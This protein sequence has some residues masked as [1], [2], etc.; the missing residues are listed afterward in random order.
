MIV[1]RLENERYLEVACP[2]WCGGED[3]AEIKE[4]RGSKHTHFEALESAAAL[5]KPIIEE[6]IT[7]NAVVHSMADFIMKGLH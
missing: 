7:A 4:R 3:T 5:A 2:C 6:L 1:S